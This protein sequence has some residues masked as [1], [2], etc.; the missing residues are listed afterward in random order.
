MQTTVAKTFLGLLKEHKV[1]D[2]I[3][4]IKEHLSERARE[5]ALKISTQVAEEC[6]MKKK[7]NEEDDES[8]EDDEDMKDEKDEKE[9]EDESEEKDED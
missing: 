4:V 2:A 3:E 8:A 6:G 7:V 1:L 5:E 9:D